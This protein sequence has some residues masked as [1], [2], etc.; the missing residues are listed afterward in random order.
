M[1]GPQVVIKLNLLSISAPCS[2]NA[3]DSHDVRDV[4]HKSTSI[5]GRQSSVPSTK[6]S[7]CTNT[8]KLV[9]LK[10]LKTSLNSY[11]SEFLLIE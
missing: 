4:N 8:G 9:M 6:S 11:S 10:K 3:V 5:Q 1:I 7:E 2:I